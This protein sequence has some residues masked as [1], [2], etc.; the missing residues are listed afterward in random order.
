MAGSRRRIAVI[1]SGVAGLTAAYVL[2]RECDVTLFEADDRVGGR[3]HTHDVV[4]DG[5]ILAVESGF[6]VHNDRA[7]PRLVRLF[8]EL[9]VR[10][11]EAEMSLSVRCLGCGLEYAGGKGPAGWFARPA[12]TTRPAFL[13]LLSQI[14]R[15]R[16]L[17]QR[18]ARHGSPVETLG[19]FLKRYAFSRYFADH[20]A[21]PLVS[22]FW[23][24]GPGRVLD[25]PARFLFTFLV[26]HG[27]LSFSDRQWRTVAGGSRSYVDLVTKRLHSVRTGDPVRSVT[28]HP[29]GVRIRD[30][31]GSPADYDGV[32]MATHAP[33]ALRM[34][35]DST[36]RERRVLGAF[37]YE[38]N[39]ALLHTD[40]SVLPRRA[41]ANSNLVLPA[42][43]V[44]GVATSGPRVSHDLNRIQRLDANQ[45]YVVTLND[46]AAVD[47]AA[48]IERIV[49]EHPLYTVESVAAQR[50]LPSLNDG[51]TAFAGAYHGWGFPEDGCR[52]GVAAAAALGVRW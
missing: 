47:P 2:Q 17:A 45:R 36:E 10:T 38:H 18:H 43:R 34:L 13:G 16:R 20:F 37:R 52:S 46:V 24:C 6:P 28:R 49:C 21:V 42:C 1:G 26:N 30:S 5:R 3:A 14:P 7:C 50:L 33:Q 25:H 27:A 48:V 23:S 4:D 29:D 41:R 32:V 9:G 39:I 19:G 22:A 11:R 31:L 51:R 44:G 40:A 35:T 15:F 12:N 8:R